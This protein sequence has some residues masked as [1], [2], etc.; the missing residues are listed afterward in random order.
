MKTEANAQ[1]AR[2]ERKAQRNSKLFQQEKLATTDAANVRRP[3]VDVLDTVG[4]ENTTHQVHQE[5]RGESRPPHHSTAR[6]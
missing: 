5:G 6:L 3:Q 2:F 1:T 4:T